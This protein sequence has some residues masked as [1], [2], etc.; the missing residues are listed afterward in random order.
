MSWRESQ[1]AVLN[2]EVR[3][4]ILRYRLSNWPLP[5]SFDHAWRGDESTNARATKEAS[6]G[7]VP[8]EGLIHFIDQQNAGLLEVEFEGDDLLAV[9]CCYSVRGDG[10]VLFG[11]RGIC[12]EGSVW[13]SSR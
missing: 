4:S 3:R 6:E 13:T 9:A 2:Q 10:R 7:A 11:R 12:V 1:F 8:L 5:F